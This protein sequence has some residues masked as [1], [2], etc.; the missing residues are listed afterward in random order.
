MP[1][2]LVLDK[3]PPPIVGSI[4]ASGVSWFLVFPWL[5]R[6]R[7][8]Q[9]WKRQRYGLSPSLQALTLDQCRKADFEGRAQTFSITVSL[10]CPAVHLYEL[11]RY[12]EPQAQ[13]ASS[14]AQT[15]I[16]L[17]EQLKGVWQ[18]KAIDALPGVAHN[19]LNPIPGSFQFNANPPSG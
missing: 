5:M 14:A 15:G 10:D 18:E 4:P 9:S 2:S 1:R 7:R 11:T 13:A 12:G 6:Q 3:Q 8:L 16:S 17:S 19:D